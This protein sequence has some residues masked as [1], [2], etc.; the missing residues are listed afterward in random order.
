M[1]TPSGG[2]TPWTE[3]EKNEHAIYGKQE[4]EQLRQPYSYVAHIQIHSPAT[5][6]CLEKEKTQWLALSWKGRLFWHFSSLLLNKQ[7]NKA[8]TKASGWASPVHCH[9][10]YIHSCW[11]PCGK[12]MVPLAVRTGYWAVFTQ[13]S[14]DK[15]K[16]LQN[17]W[18]SSFFA[19]FDYLYV[20]CIFGD[21]KRRNWRTISTFLGF[22]NVNHSQGYF[23]FFLS[24]GTEIH[25]VIERV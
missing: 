8:L 1:L 5:V 2:N 6:N 21:R 7:R 14:K 20:I 23:F 10:P 11:W 18:T 19:I 16:K 17:K 15:N 24:Q 22:Q 3:Q 9:I 12:P 13:S 4:A 25:T